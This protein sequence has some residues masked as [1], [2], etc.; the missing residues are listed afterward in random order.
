MNPVILEQNAGVQAGA[1]FIIREPKRYLWS[2]A[3]Y[4]NTLETG[5]DEYTYAESADDNFK[6]MDMT[7][8]V[9]LNGDE[10]SIGCTLGCLFK[11]ILIAANGIIDEC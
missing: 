8:L 7:G 1:Y 11:E 2:E 4:Y 9:E 3:Y 6:V 10:S 5:T